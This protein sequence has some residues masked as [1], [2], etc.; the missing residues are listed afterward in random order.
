MS[1]RH[2]VIICILSMVLTA[3]VFLPSEFSYHEE[4]SAAEKGIVNWATTRRQTYM[5]RKAAVWEI[6]AYM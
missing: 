6:W 5:M 2:I 4:A 3:A 1:H